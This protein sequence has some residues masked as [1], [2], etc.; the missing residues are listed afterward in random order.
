MP[1]Q[2]WVWRIERAGWYALLLLVML[3][4][5]G[6]FSKGPLSDAT[7]TGSLGHLQVDYQRFAR[8]GATSQLVLTLRETATQAQIFIS[9][10]L[11]EGYTIE[12]IQP[13]PLAGSNGEQGGLRLAVATE[14]G[15]ARLSLILRAEGVGRFDS[16]IGAGGERVEL[17]QFIYP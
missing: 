17:N 5:L 3:A 4:L 12:S 1:L 16:W 14:Q 6:L 9:S 7:V 2:L 8:G 15:A 11:L 13:A 10:E